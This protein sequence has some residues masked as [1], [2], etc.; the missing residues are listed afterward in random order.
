M[1]IRPE[2]AAL[3][4]DDPDVQDAVV[5]SRADSSWTPVDIGAALRGGVPEVRPQLLK[6]TDGEALLYPGRTHWLSG[7]PETGKSWIALAAAR[8]AIWARR[9][10]VYVDFEDS[11]EGT[12]GRLMALCLAVEEVSAHFHY[13]NPQEAAR[14]GDLDWLSDLRPALVVVDGVSESITLH[15]LDPDRTRDIVEWRRRMLSPLRASGAAVLALD[16]VV[17]SRDER[18]RWPIGSQ[19][20]LGALDGAA[21]S[22]EAI[23][24]FSRTHAGVSRLTVVKDRPGQVRA[25]AAEGKHAGDFRLTPGDDGA[26]VA[27]ITPPAQRESPGGLYPADR[28]V[29]GV[30]PT[31]Q[32]AALVQREIGDRLASDGEGPPLKASTIDDCL[33]RLRREGMVDGIAEGRGKVGLWW[34]TS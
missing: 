3:G 29:L 14:R 28:R 10:V 20:K 21:Y 30:L 9:A 1:T 31:E 23:S 19:H 16:H 22:L 12:V 13:V 17:K 2:L 4:I 15:S 33:R 6:R 8:E 7:E 25:F 27:E 24:P 26:V 5:R 18:G 11:P 32:A 34:R